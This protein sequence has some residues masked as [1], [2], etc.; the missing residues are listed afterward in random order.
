M[1]T[2]LLFFCET[3]TMAHLMRTWA[4]LKEVDQSRFEV[5]LAAG[6]VPEFL[7]KEI[8]QHVQLW[9][10][11][12]APRSAD[13]LRHLANGTLPYT[14]EFVDAQVQ[15]DLQ[16]IEKIQPDIVAGDFRISLIIS[17]RAKKVPYINLTNITWHPDASLAHS[18]PDHWITRAIG[19]TLALPISLLAQPIVLHRASQAYAA[20]A[21]KYGVMIPK[22]LLKIYIAGD[23]VFYADTGKI[24]Q[25]VELLPHEVIGGP[26]L[27]SIA[28]PGIQ[29]PNFPDNRPT[30]VISLGSS[31]PQTKIHE[32]VAALED[33]DLNLL[34]STSGQNLKLKNPER[35]F[36]SHFLPLDQVLKQANALIF[37]GGSATGYMGLA[38]G[39]P[40]FSIPTNI[41][42]MK[43]T[44]AIVLRGAGLRM[45]IEQLN[46][47][48][49]QQKLQ[50]L[51][52]DS[53]YLQAAR[54]L[55]SEI[56]Q[57][58]AVTKFQEI[59]NRTAWPESAPT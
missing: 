43:F 4:L 36:V 41:D 25:G 20:T 6:E 44:N 28:S 49:L 17:A 24:V 14:T 9:P 26:I 59:L 45:R 19:E 33:L 23:C 35:A 40:L 56:K 42:Q 30:V 5:H 12:T 13:F 50:Q 21:A 39:V 10:L 27:A 22:G 16:L 34:I 54:K 58:N 31:G 18:I 38:N 51:L 52:S 55:Q 32:I 7:N 47:R 2:K 48:S 3:V 29:I 53:S 11:H 46:R 1:R 57:E 37:N 8:S 15:E